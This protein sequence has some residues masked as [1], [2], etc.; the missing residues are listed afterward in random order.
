MLQHTIYRAISRGIG[1]HIRV[2]VK[3]GSALLNALFERM[4]GGMGGAASGRG[5]VYLIDIGYCSGFW[6][7]C[8]FLHPPKGMRSVGGE[9]AG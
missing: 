2:R 1:W 7:E 6:F 9:F 5:E 3:T 4:R 8:E